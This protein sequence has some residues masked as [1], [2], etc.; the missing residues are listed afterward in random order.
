M[1]QTIPAVKYAYIGGS[2]TWAGDFPL[3]I[4]LKGV[5]VLEDNLVFQTPYGETVPL[6]LLKLDKEITADHKDRLVLSAAFHGWHS[7]DAPANGPEQ[8]FWVFMQAGV[9]NIVVEGSGGG[10]NTLLDPGD[11]II[12][13]DYIDMRKEPTVALIPNK[14]VRML[15][16]FCPTL[17]DTLYQEAQKEFPRVFNR[18]VYATSQGP[19][20][21]SAAE[22]K[23]LHNAH[24]DIAGITLSPEVYYAR[25]IGAHIASIYLIS[26]YAEGMITNWHG[27]EIFDLY[28]DSAPKIGRLMLRTL[29]N[30]GP[31]ECKCLD[32]RT[33]VDAKVQKNLAK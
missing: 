12:P 11:L 10:I 27:N 31:N 23:M 8:I 26:N 2:G 15:D 21:E 29:A 5:E 6:K 22:V 13:S 9:K 4:G 7:A 3:D 30:C 20:F 16:P 33:D 32:Y 1:T 18:G 24:A 17:R 19:R 25:L 14:I 28:K